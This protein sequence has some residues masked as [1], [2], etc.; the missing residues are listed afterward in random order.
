M[1]VTATNHLS[2]KTA[3]LAE[4]FWVQQPPTGLHFCD[5][6]NSRG[7]PAFKTKVGESIT[8][9]ANVTSGDNVTFDWKLGDQTDLVKAGRL[10]QILFCVHWLVNPSLFLTVVGSVCACKVG[11]L[12]LIFPSRVPYLL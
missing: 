8:L 11:Y 12:C 4:A 9:C 3:L 2:N 7:M 5:K 6:S 10:A 1:K